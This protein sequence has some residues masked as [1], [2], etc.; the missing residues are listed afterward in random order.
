MHDINW[1]FVTHSNFHRLLCEFENI[2]LKTG[3]NGD[4]I[5][6]RDVGRVELGSKDYSVYCEKNGQPSAGVAVYQLP[7]A[8]ALDLAETIQAKMVEL[9][10]RFPTGLVYDIPFNTTKFV[11]ASIECHFIYFKA[12]HL[13]NCNV[14]GKI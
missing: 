7:G 3:D 4:L 6:L 13:I 8:N 10:K 12:K 9:S 2:I 1:T 11:K 5:Y 14:R